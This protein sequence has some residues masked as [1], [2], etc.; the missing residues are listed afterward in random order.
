MKLT[1]ISLEDECRVIGSL[2]A[3]FH[4]AKSSANLLERTFV[5]FDFTS[6]MRRNIL[7]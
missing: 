2:K 5:C 3:D 4:E 1:Q 6:E 7:A